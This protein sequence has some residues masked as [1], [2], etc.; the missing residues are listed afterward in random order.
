M[1]FGAFER[2]WPVV[3]SL[4]RVTCIRHYVTSIECNAETTFDRVTGDEVTDNNDG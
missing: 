1:G 4:S 3:D 2:G